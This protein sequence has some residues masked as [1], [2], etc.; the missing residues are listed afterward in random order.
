[1]IDHLDYVPADRG[2]CAAIFEMSK[3]LIER[4]EDLSAIDYENVLGWV[5]RKIETRIGEYWLIQKD[6]KTVGYYRLCPEARKIELDDFYILPDY[7]N[8]GIGTLT[9][10]KII[11]EA[12]CPV[13]LYVFKKNKGAVSLYRRMGFAEAEQV[14][15]TRCILCR[16]A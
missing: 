14:S 11:S 8:Q 9:L 5:R 4:Y 6:G 10:Q 16:N 15:D 12:K 3:E 1:M 2:D 13:F 7:R